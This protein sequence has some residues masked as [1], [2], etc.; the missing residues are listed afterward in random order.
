[1]AKDGFLIGSSINLKPGIAPSSPVE[2]DVYYNDASN[3]LFFHNGSAFT[4]LAASSSSR[5]FRSVSASDSITLSDDIILGDATS[6]DVILNLPA[7]ASSSGAQFTVKKTDSSFNLVAL[8]SNLSELI[9]A[10]TQNAVLATKNDCLQISCDGSAWYIL[11][12]SIPSIWTAYTPNTN[13]FGTVSSMSAFWKREG[14]S[15]SAYGYFVAGTT[16]ATTANIALPTGLT[17]DVNKLP[18][19]QKISVGTFFGNVNSTGT[20]VPVITRGPWAMTVA[21]GSPTRVIV[22][23]V[24]DTSDTLFTPLSANSGVSTGTACTFSFKVPIEGWIN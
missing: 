9:D 11:N 23:R 5:S 7:V 18:M 22:S 14:D 1:M 2:G 20:T 17:V 10:S 3:A 16:T 8:N 19:S 13:G 21:S 24:V 12:K 4:E 6:G 15:L